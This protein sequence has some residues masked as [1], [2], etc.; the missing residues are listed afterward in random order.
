MVVH[1]GKSDRVARRKRSTL[2]DLKI[3]IDIG[4]SSHDTAVNEQAAKQIMSRLKVESK[5]K[6]LQFSKQLNGFKNWKTIDLRISKL[7]KS[8]VGNRTEEACA[9]EVDALDEDNPDYMKKCSKCC[10]TKSCN[11]CNLSYQVSMLGGAL[12]QHTI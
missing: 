4:V 1:C 2:K 5:Q 10:F 9:D 12:C 11:I 3:R 7:I 6:A 8:E